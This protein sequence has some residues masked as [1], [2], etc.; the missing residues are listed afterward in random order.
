MLH[1][2]NVETCLGPKQPPKPNTIFLYFLLFY[3]HQFSPIHLFSLQPLKESILPRV[4]YHPSYLFFFIFGLEQPI[5][6][7]GKKSFLPPSSTKLVFLNPLT[8]K[9]VC[10]YT[11][12]SFDNGFFAN[13]AR[14]VNRTKLKVEEVNQNRNIF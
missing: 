11:L 5:L 4:A 14:G 10:F 13:V 9:T 8:F 2:G 1:L 6:L 3:F 7:L 12:A